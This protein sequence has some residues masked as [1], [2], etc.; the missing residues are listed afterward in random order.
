MSSF[1]NLN[2]E[3]SRLLR[4]ELNWKRLFFVP[5]TALLILYWNIDNADNDNTG[6]YFWFMLFAGGWGSFS[7][8]WDIKETLNNRTW[9]WQLILPLSPLQLL[10]GRLLGTLVLPWFAGLLVLLPALP[11]RVALETILLAFLANCVAFFLALITVRDD[12]ADML[13]PA[14]LTVAV[15][16]IAPAIS[17]SVNGV[18]IVWHIWIIPQPLFISLTYIAYSAWALVGCYQLLA[19]A[20]Q[21]PPRP[22]LFLLFLIFH[23]IYG[24]GFTHNHSIFLSPFSDFSLYLFFIWVLLASALYLNIFL[25]GKKGLLLLL[26]N[27]KQRLVWR[28]YLPSWV[29]LLALLLITTLIFCASVAGTNVMWII[30]A[31]TLL[32]VRDVTILLLFA[33]RPGSRFPE[34]IT[35]IVLLVLYVFLPYLLETSGVGA[36]WLRPLFEEPA[37]FDNN[38]TTPVLIS[39]LSALGQSALALFLL[40]QL[41]LARYKTKGRAL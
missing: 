2:A 34:G 4:C 37:A 35:A 29:L 5:L 21:Y 8:I 41:R 32:T 19:H 18:D 11:S 12:K 25:C 38:T 6:H 36:Y 28:Q 7:I 16:M 15:L 10:L 33:L 31:W 30:L 9:Y 24:T 14:F 39:A 1:L 27:I 23:L 13:I 3:L 26:D 20:K 17:T 22:L 40:W